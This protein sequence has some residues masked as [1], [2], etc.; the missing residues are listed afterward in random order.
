[1]HPRPFPVG[2]VYTQAPTAFL[3][4]V[5]DLVVIGKCMTFTTMEGLLKKWS[6]MKFALAVISLA[7]TLRS[8]CVL[9]QSSVYQNL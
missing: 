7:L 5:S 1:M 4:I 8:T 3:E 9:R 6:K 2:I